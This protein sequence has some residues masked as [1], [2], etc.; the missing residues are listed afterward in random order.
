M[1]FARKINFTGMRFKILGSRVPDLINGQLN[2]RVQILELNKASYL[3]FLYLGLILYARYK[4]IFGPLT[5]VMFNINN[6]AELTRNTTCHTFVDLGELSAHTQEFKFLSFQKLHKKD[7]LHTSC[8][9]V[10]FT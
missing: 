7:G 3:V 2:C 4:R 8:V 6:L 1:V 10:Q 5:V 9:S